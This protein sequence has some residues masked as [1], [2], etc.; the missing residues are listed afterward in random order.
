MNI[1]IV[2]TWFDRGAAYVSRQ[3]R[4]VLKAKHNV[5]IYARGGETYAKGDPVW[6]D[7]RVTWAKKSIF[8]SI[9]A[10]N[11]AD[12]QSWLKLNSIDIVFFNEQHQWEPI[13]LCN[14]LGIKTGGYIDYYTKETV[15][16]FGCY[17]FLIC[18]TKRHYRVFNWHSQAFFIPWGTDT[19]L[20]KPTTL[21]PV[22]PDC[23]TFFH[24]GGM[25]PE[26][27]GT[28]LV[29][30][31]FARLRGHA[32]LVIHVQ[33][34]L[35]QC[36][37]NL[38]NLIQ[39]MENEGRLVCYEKTVPAP[40]LYHLGD[41]YVYPSRLEGIG[42]TI[43]EALA[44]GLPVITSNNPPMNEF[45][46]DSNGSLVKISRLFMRE[47]NYYWPQ[48]VVD[49]DNLCECMQ[50]YVD[51]GSRLIEFKQAAR[52]YAEVHLDWSKNARDVP[53]LFERVQMRTPEEKF[54]AELEARAFDQK[55][56]SLQQRFLRFINRTSRQ[57]VKKIRLSSR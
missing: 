15:P 20:F 30:K 6:D 54:I 32:R 14:E 35:K 9:H 29:V 3:Y 1:G 51:Q 13:F 31:A 5:F 24:S 10:V 57:A 47:D 28:D 38:R 17:D 25:S 7:D 18:N 41:V 19:N 2:T 48:C 44:C 45:I 26:R 56:W 50:N 40:G 52:T 27:K 36:F 8:Q 23:V 33:R 16:F 46:D 4:D 42:L 12:F 49:V 11:K 34:N 39:S 53:L 55:L 37:P 21:S 43:A 22:M